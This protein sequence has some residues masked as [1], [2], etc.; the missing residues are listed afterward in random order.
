M[1]SQGSSKAEVLR[2]AYNSV[3]VYTIRCVLTRCAG[4]GRAEWGGVRKDAGIGAGAATRGGWRG[5]AGVTLVF[6]GEVCTRKLAEQIF[7]VATM[8]KARAGNTAQALAAVHTAA[9][10]RVDRRI[11]TGP[12]AA[13][14]GVTRLG[15]K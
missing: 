9:P 1:P 13:R 15:A 14:S 8:F 4:S 5:L 11:L 12:A 6:V 7:A 3:Q 10:G 2:K